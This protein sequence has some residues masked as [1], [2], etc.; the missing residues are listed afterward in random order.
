MP[1]VGFYVLGLASFGLNFLGFLT[2]SLQNHARKYN[3]PIDHLTFQ[4]NPLKRY[5]QQADVKKAMEELKFGEELEMDKE[6]ERPD[7]GV[8]VHG[9][10]MDGCRWVRR[11]AGHV[12]FFS[13]I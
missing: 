2:G 11:R 12:D 1:P 9:L 6:L 3:L 5:R 13:L 10:F 8:I 7:D 4:F